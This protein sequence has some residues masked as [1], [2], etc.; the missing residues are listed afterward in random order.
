ME[1]EDLREFAPVAQ[2]EF[3][4][5]EAHQKEVR[6]LKPVHEDLTSRLTDVIDSLTELS[7]ELGCRYGMFVHLDQVSEDVD[8]MTGTTLPAGYLGVYIMSLAPDRSG[9]GFH[10]T[11]NPQLGD[12]LAYSLTYFFVRGEQLKGLSEDP[13]G[14]VLM[15]EESTLGNETSARGRNAHRSERM[16]LEELPSSHYTPDNVAHLQ[17]Y[18]ENYLPART[19]QIQ[20][21]ERSLQIIKAALDNPELNPTVE[22]IRTD[23]ELSARTEALMNEEDDHEEAAQRPRRRLFRN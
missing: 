15:E 16:G 14:A 22:L 5:R 7:N 4:A 19:A 18:I 11:A 3:L 12:N 9:S 17:N 20:T 21:L 13:R 6:S 2:N 10:P 1:L 23:N 8:E